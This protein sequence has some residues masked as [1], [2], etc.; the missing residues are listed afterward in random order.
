MDVD[1]IPGT[2][3][4]ERQVV[5]VVSN[6]LANAYGTGD[7]R[8]QRSVLSRLAADCRVVFF[9]LH[10]RRGLFAQPNLYTTLN[11]LGPDTIQGTIPVAPFI[12]LILWNGPGCV[13]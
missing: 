10:I 4:R 2:P 11:N 1:Q 13:G 7:C 8:G 6:H 12:V 3:R 9:Q 5:K